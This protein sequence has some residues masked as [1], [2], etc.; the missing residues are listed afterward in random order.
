VPVVPDSQTRPD[1]EPHR[2]EYPRVFETRNRGSRDSAP[3]QPA[4]VAALVPT[5][6]GRST[7][8]G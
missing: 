8:N 4:A 5:S 7:L 1:S 2:F 6:A 3:A